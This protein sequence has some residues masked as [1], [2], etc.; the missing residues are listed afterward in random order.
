VHPEVTAEITIPVTMPKDDVTVVERP[1]RVVPALILGTGVATLA[2]G[3]VLYFTSEEDTGEKLYYRDT[4]L[5][6][7]GVAAGGVVVTAV[8]TWLWIRSGGEP[9]S[10]PVASLDAHGG[11]V[12]WSH[13]F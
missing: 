10:A 1:S 7:I 9:D 12:G 4:K 2:A 3:A 8:G 5:P 13:A 11:T 6:G